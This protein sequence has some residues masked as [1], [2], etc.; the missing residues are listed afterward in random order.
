MSNV[1]SSC[2]TNQL[3]K[4]K[5]QTLLSMQRNIVIETFTDRQS[6]QIRFMQLS[7]LMDYLLNAII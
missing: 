4:R 5:F 2:L 7:Y 1:R 6:N 3:L